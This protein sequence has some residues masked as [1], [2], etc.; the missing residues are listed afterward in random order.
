MRRRTLR[1]SL[2]S[3]KDRDV[4]VDRAMHML[5][6]RKERV[7][8]GSRVEE[9]GSWDVLPEISKKIITWKRKR[10]ECELKM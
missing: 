4:V 8:Y 2:V 3:T 7:V 10:T 9:R 5:E 1:I 6:T